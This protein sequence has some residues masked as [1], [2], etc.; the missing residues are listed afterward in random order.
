MDP[1]E[2]TTAASGPPSPVDWLRLGASPGD[3]PPGAVQIGH[4]VVLRVL[5]SGGMG[6]VYSAYDEKLDRK[7]A[8]KLLRGDLSAHSTRRQTRMVREA[9]AMAKLSHPNVVQ[10]YEVGTHGGQVFLAMEFIEGGNLRRWLKKEER[11]WREVLA[12]FIQAG[13]GVAAAHR[14]GIIHRDFKPDNVLVDE[15]GTAKVTD[16]GTAR[17]AVLSGEHTPVSDE[18]TE[19]VT[20]E[21]NVSGSASM[22]DQRLTI[23]GRAVG[24]PAYMSPEQHFGDAVDARSDQFGFCIALYEALYGDRPFRAPDRA[25]LAARVAEGTIPDAPP[26]SGVPSWVRKAVL[27]GLATEP[28]DRF[29][30]MD[31]L[32]LE[33]DRDPYRRRKWLAGGAVAAALL[34]GAPLVF[35]ADAPCQEMD[36]PLFGVW[37][38]ARKQS[39]ERAFLATELPFAA[40]AWKSVEASFDRYT[41]GWVETRTEACEAT[42]EGSQSDDMLDLR[43][44]CLDRRLGSLSSLTGLF[45]KA[46]SQVVEN[47]A[48]AA[49]SLPDLAFC[50]NTEA[51]RLAVRPPEDP[52]TARKV[53]D[54]R[55]TLDEVA[56]LELAGRYKESLHLAQQAVETARQIDYPPVLAEA[57]FHLGKAQAD[58]RMGTKT[59][60]TLK[61]AVDLAERSRHDELAADLWILLVQLSGTQIYDLE[62]AHERLRRASAAVERIGDKGARLATMLGIRGELY[63]VESKYEAAEADARRALEIRRK[64]GD[65][66][67]AAQALRLLANVLE[68]R[69]DS[70]GAA[71]AYE[72]AQS[73]AVAHLGEK[74]PQVARLLLHL[75]GHLVDQGRLEEAEPYLSRAQAVFIET[76]GEDSPKLGEVHLNLL[77]L[78]IMKGDLALA[79]ERAE[80]ARAAINA[81]PDPD[82]A[83]LAETLNLLG[84]IAFTEGR[85]EDALSLYED[86]RSR[87][88]RI[89]GNEHVFVGYDR[90]NAGEALIA[91]GRYGEAASQFA[92]SLAILEGKLP[93]DHETLAYPLKG[94]GQA[95]LGLGSAQLAI[96]PLERALVIRK[97]AP[98]NPPELAAIQ[99]HLARALAASGRDRER[100]R[101]LAKQAHELFASMEDATN[102]DEISRWLARQR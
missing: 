35:T 71:A 29:A 55:A 23:T 89:F 14:A 33:L 58:L 67:R 36:A 68:A 51:L 76:Y 20:E 43:M 82:E 99:W 2:T 92:R 15:A 90:S 25:A 94:S 80:S 79:K 101:Q 5:G 48:E 9:Q 85:F 34:A 1:G 97:A 40:D 27:R 47:A 95:L 49:S 73:D 22:L 16:F 70:Q 21:P 64:L 65:E 31:A 44:A 18:L 60:D 42:H 74:H 24:T 10:I 63:Y 102:A 72:R 69:G 8:V 87:N 81:A 38:D 57:L 26:G 75:G 98:E 30:D 56:S 46:D 53:K 66:M 39:I 78:A 83:E 3:A 45:V 59:A 61:E 37:D 54:L 12:M 100:A 62:Q 11:S 28:D 96:E 84:T 77:K 52:Q 88:E 17:A 32:L 41:Q 7:V 19:E 4:F 86:A 93:D 13:R 50:N 91:L 6:I